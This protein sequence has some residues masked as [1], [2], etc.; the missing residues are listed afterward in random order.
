MRA[1][2]E[3]EAG[4]VSGPNPQVLSAADG[5]QR[6][7]ER[8]RCVRS[9]SHNGQMA[10]G[11][12]MSKTAAMRFVRAVDLYIADQRA[13]GRIN[14]PA[15][16][17]DY[18]Y[19][20]G[21]HADDVDNRDP[22]NTTRDDV[23]RTLGRWDHPN[24]RS[25]NRAILVSFYRWMVEEGL[26]PHNPASQTKR[27][28]RLKTTRYRLTQD[29]ALQVLQAVRT[30]R[31]RRAIYLALCA[32]LRRQEL[33]GMQGR[34]FRR[35]GWVWVSADIGKG[36]KERWIPV[37]RDLELVWTET[38]RHVADDEYVLPAQR[39]R[40]PG[41][42]RERR[43][44]ATSPA[45]YQAIWNLVKDVAKRAGIPAEITPH[46]LRHAYCDHVA[47]H[48]GL[49]VA[50]AAMGHANLSTTELYLGAPTLDELAH[51]MR[52]VTL[53]GE[54]AFVRD[55]QAFPSPGKRAAIAGEA[56]TGIEPV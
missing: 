51:A 30:T 54:Q 21:C 9:S 27:P 20:L 50:Q 52:N 11:A 5:A 25:K 44:Y 16:E 22:A 34:H 6:A 45:S 10:A 48:A 41:T 14:S 49:Q 13:D 40:D 23:K 8:L 56:P 47:R 42:N 43:D 2:W 1:V 32:G 33:R 18:R 39:F 19:T 55:E 3:A 38:A 31:E 26:R 15:T 35:V 37:I 24:S 7:A 17:R 4:G 46:T 12:S 28:R 29:E 53:G 36:H